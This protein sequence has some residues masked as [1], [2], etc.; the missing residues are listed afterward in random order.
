MARQ[1]AISGSVTFNGQP[2]SGAR[3]DILD[4][5]NNLRVVVQWSTNG[6]GG[7]SGTCSLTE[8]DGKVRV[9]ARVSATGHPIA[10]RY[11]TT[12]GNEIIFGVISL[13]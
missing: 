2:M 5:F 6:T 12:S 4:G 1:V 11:R 10:R 13:T 8:S 9:Y 3:V 7:F